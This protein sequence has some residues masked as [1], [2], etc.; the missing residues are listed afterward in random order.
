M[1]QIAR[2][3]DFACQPV[4]LGQIACNTV[5]KLTARSYNS[6]SSVMS[7]LFAN[8][9]CDPFTA[10]E[11]QCVLGTYVQYAVDVSCENDVVN[12]LAFVQENNIRLVIRN[13]GH[14]YNGKSTGAGALAIWTHHLKDIVVF[15][16][17]TSHYTGK[18][19]KM[20]AG[21]QAFEA[22]EAAHEENL[23]IVGGECPTV[24]L[25]GGYVSAFRRVKVAGYMTE[26]V[27][28]CCLALRVSV[29]CQ[30]GFRVMGELCTREGPLSY[31]ND[32]AKA[33]TDS[34][35]FFWAYMSLGTPLMLFLL[36]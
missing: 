31:T 20:G 1:L 21:V 13:T 9:S 2:G 17:E 18:A 22:Y 8:E 10:R 27:R 11:S 23:A 6:S 25:A 4:R 34:W 5:S 35:K 14:D 7:P 16:Y 3:L 15:D 28:S 32:M 19:M 26:G 30:D 29:S 36:L 12:T 24:G 33:V